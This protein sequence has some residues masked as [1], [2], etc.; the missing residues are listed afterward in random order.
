MAA[1]LLGASV[2]EAAS[3]VAKDWPGCEADSVAL[4]A[5]PASPAAPSVTEVCSEPPPESEFS[6]A[7]RSDASEE[8]VTA[9]ALLAGDMPSTSTTANAMLVSF[10]P[11]LAPF[12]FIF[13]ISS[14]L[15]VGDL[16]PLQTCKMP[17]TK[18]KAIYAGLRRRGY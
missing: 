14:S 2:L 16:Q 18:R 5:L 3:S 11:S 6:A 7:A 8:A 9:A 10:A 4:P 12:T 1:E 13:F 15:P 17:C